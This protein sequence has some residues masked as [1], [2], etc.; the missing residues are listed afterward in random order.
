MLSQLKTNALN[1][2]LFESEF[3]EVI[4]IV[5]NSTEQESNYVESVSLESESSIL[6][7]STFV[8]KLM[9]FVVMNQKKQEGRD[10]SRIEMWWY[11][12]LNSTE[13]R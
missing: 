7:P 5:S 9:S 11:L 6:R 3:V 8:E 4:Y 12:S 2:V 1:T 13:T 10:R